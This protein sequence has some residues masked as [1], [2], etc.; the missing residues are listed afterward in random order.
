M[1][2]LFKENDDEFIKINNNENVQEEE[3]ENSSEKREEEMNQ[4]NIYNNND[5]EL[6]NI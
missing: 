2:D 4:I 1:E 3:Q 5:F 6:D